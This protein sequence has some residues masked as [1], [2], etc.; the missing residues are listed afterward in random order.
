MNSQQQPTMKAATQGPD[1]AVS[2]TGKLQCYLPLKPED[3][4]T[5]IPVVLRHYCI[6]HMCGYIAGH[7]L[8]YV[9]NNKEHQT[10]Q[11]LGT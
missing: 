8:L 11:D 9:H 10:L 7:S 4:P 3:R 6:T 5:A 2:A 1:Y